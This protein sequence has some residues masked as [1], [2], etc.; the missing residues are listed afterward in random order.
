MNIES[1]RG[2][3]ARYP[4]LTEKE[5][6]KDRKRSRRSYLPL[7]RLYEQID[8]IKNRAL[9]HNVAGGFKQESRLQPT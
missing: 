6:A 8:S 7:Q 5:S 2:L 4:F 1:Y 9:R 3:Q